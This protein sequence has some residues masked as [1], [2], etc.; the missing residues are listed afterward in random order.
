MRYPSTNGT[1]FMCGFNWYFEYIYKYLNIEIRTKD[2]LEAGIENI[3]I[4]EAEVLADIKNTATK[5]I[6][7]LIGLL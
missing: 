5:E 4:A 7:N 3:S 1:F 6:S 2:D